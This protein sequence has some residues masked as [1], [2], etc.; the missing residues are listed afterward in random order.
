MK[1]MIAILLTLIMAVAITGTTASAMTKNTQLVTVSAVS[2]RKTQSTKAKV[3]VKVKKGTKVASVTQSK[4][5]WVKVKT[6]SG[7]TGYVQTKYVKNIGTKK[8]AK[9][10]YYCA[11]PS[12]NGCWASW[13]SGAWST[14]TSS[15]KRLYNKSSYKWLYCAATP[16]VGKLGQ[17]VTVYLDGAWRRLKIVDRMGSS[18]GSR[19]DVF[20]PSHSGC[21]SHG[22]HWNKTVYVK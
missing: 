8:T 12:C 20:Y 6:T 14:A 4:S 15:G 22:V 1:K 10:T 5:G 3:V 19:I 2:L 21:Y 18:Y 11:C 13:R 7:K 9:I 16:S 17:T